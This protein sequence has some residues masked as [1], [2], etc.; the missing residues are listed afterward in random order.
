MLSRPPTSDSQYFTNMIRPNTCNSTARPS[1]TPDPLLLKNPRLDIYPSVRQHKPYGEIKH[2]SNLG[3][4]SYEYHDYS[5]R[6]FVF[7]TIFTSC[8][9]TFFLVD[10]KQLLA[11]VLRSVEAIFIL[12]ILLYE[13][14]L[15]LPSALI[16]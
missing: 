11:L 5:N 6:C 8:F 7:V 15:L 9:V 3:P 1:T 4:G 13:D 16:M 14:R 2:S 10:R 12:I